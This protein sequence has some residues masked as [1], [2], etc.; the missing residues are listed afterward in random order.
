MTAIAILTSDLQY[1]KLLMENAEG[2][3]ETFPTFPKPSNMN[4]SKKLK[5]L[6]RTLY[7]PKA[8]KLNFC[9][10]LTVSCMLI[11]NVNA[12]RPAQCSH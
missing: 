4:S 7:E 3:R 11:G 10:L 12:L 6:P 1:Q 9:V 2:I 5:G 8:T